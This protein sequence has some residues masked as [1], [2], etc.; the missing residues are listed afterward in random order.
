MV[1]TQP[2]NTLSHTVLKVIQLPEIYQSN[3]KESTLLLI[4]IN[5]EKKSFHDLLPVESAALSK[6]SFSIIMSW[7]NDILTDEG[8]GFCGFFSVNQ[9]IRFFYFCIPSFL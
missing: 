2:Q 8:V 6:S 1:Y 5:H 7:F 3:L 9:S 4:C